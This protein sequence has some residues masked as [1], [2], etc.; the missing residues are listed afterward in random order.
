[1]AAAAKIESHP[2]TV[3]GFGEFLEWRTLRFVQPMPK[4]R[5]CQLCGVVSSVARLLPCTHI[6]CESCE[7]QVS[8][9]GRPRCP[10]DDAA[11]EREHVT[12]MPF[13]KRDLDEYHVH[14]I[15]SNVDVS[16][17][18]DGCAFI[19]KLAA[20]EEH[21]LAHCVHGRV[22][23]S[24][25]GRSVLRKDTVEHYVGCEG[26]EINTS[27]VEPVD[28]GKVIIDAAEAKRLAG[29]LKD[30]QR[31]LK[32]ASPGTPMDHGEL[33]VAETQSRLPG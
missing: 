8:V 7:A 25:C 32:D 9:R 14:C 6:L 27:P 31:G 10:I 33:R 21:Y 13:A 1:M 28:D 16:D 4:I 18:S 12:N 20:L 5:V 2:Y 29:T 19:G 15:N 22:H 30:L 3:T 24:K 26:A 17:G 23:C 11:F